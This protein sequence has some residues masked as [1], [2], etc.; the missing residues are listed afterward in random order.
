MGIFIAGILGAVLGAF[1]SRYAIAWYLRHRARKNLQGDTVI[2][3]SP[4]CPKPG[5]PYAHRRHA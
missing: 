3:I 4:D 2:M 1:L 5:R